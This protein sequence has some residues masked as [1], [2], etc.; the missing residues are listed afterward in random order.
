MARITPPTSFSAGRRW[1]IFF[2][3]M[4][5]IAAVAALVLMLNYLG[6]RHFLRFSW[7][8]KTSLRLS[9]PTLSLLESITN[10]VK[11]TI[12]YD[13]TD[14]LYFD[15]AD[16]LNEYHLANPKISVQ[17]VD[18]GVDTVAAL[19]VSTLYRLGDKKDLIIYEC[20]G[21]YQITP[22]KDLANYT[23][24][25]VSDDDPKP[26]TADQSKPKYNKHTSEFDGERRVDADLIRVTG[27]PLQAYYLTGNGEPTLDDE[28]EGTFDYSDFAATLSDKHVNT[29]TL[30]LVGTNA[31][32]ANCNLLVIAS[33]RYALAPEELAKVGQYLAD[34]GRLL[35]LF[36]NY[37]LE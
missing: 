2:S 35:M 7:S 37:Q 23:I 11:I 3:V 32:P 16:L 26:D 29:T 1:G 17:T 31:I 27:P 36:N 33:P 6:A 14:G 13:K 15:I 21:Q 28:G 25:R 9:P 20:N 4:I 22:G 12:Y 30:S 24:D 18:Y 34:G 19:Q 5:S 8:A 10:D